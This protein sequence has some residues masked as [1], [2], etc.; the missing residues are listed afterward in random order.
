MN[1]NDL[2]ELRQIFRA[3]MRE[4]D[5]CI[6]EEEVEKLFRELLN[7]PELPEP[8]YNFGSIDT[9]K[10]GELLDK[11]FSKSMKNFER[12]DTFYNAINKSKKY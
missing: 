8:K 4:A 2:I 3:R 7:E 10:L 12:I 9:Q 6:G 11:H 5:F 1:P